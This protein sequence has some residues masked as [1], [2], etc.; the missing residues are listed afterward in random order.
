MHNEGLVPSHVCRKLYTVHLKGVG[1]GCEGLQ[2]VSISREI[3][4]SGINRSCLPLAWLASH[5]CSYALFLACVFFIRSDRCFRSV[6]VNPV[7]VHELSHA[8][9][10]KSI[11]AKQKIALAYPQLVSQA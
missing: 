10:L 2:P 5:S 1:G 3:Q 7:C 4:A 9:I 8:L 11:Q 6:S